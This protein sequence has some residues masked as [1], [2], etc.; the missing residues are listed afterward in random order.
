MIRLTLRQF[1]AEAIIA[2]AVLGAF[3]VVLAITGEQLVRVDDAFRAAC[4]TAGDCASLTDPVLELYRP[5]QIALPLT[6][7]IAPALIGLFFGAPLIAREL[8][9]GTFRLAWTQT[10]SRRW[11]LTVKLGLIGLAAMAV[12][13]VL[14]G[15]VGRWARPLDAIGQD[16][17]DPTNFGYHGIVTIGYAV[18]AFA[19]GATT[20]TLLRRTVP[21]MAVTL[22]GFVVARIAVMYW[23]RPY[24]ATPLQ[25]TLPLSDAAPS[26]SLSALIGGGQVD[27]ALRPPEVNLPNAWVYHAQLVDSAGNPPDEHVIESTC[28]ALIQVAQ[29][30]HLTKD[31]FHVCVEKLATT[32]H[33]VV[34][35]QPADR[36]WP[37]QWAET[38][39]FVA[40]ALALCGFTY[41]WIRRQYSA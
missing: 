34:T 28:P 19:L 5:L 31:D 26:F 18:F 3:A 39:L 40:A 38:A 12:G 27:I 20:G 23:V 35:Y 14:S 2:V 32:Y 29:S 4:T 17:F 10:V 41:W 7:M 36:F 11:W 25:A 24:F 30:G 21:A 8:E 37:F 9:T 22:V 13:G 1:R 33:T 15:M 16:R 6:V